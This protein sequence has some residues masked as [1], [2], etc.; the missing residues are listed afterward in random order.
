M[1]SAPHSPGFADVTQQDLRIKHITQVSFSVRTR[2]MVGVI[3]GANQ[4][5]IQY[6]K[7]LW[8]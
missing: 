8:H 6:F 2:M 5:V 7:I 4:F 3:R 1:T